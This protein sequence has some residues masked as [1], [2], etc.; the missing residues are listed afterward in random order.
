MPAFLGPLVGFALGVALA[1]LA[2]EEAARAD[3]RRLGARGVIAALYGALVFAPAAA[4]FL[5]FAGDWSYAYLLDS[6]A[7]PSAIE[8]GLV[9][10]DAASVPLGFLA[11]RRAGRD[12]RLTA[13]LGALPAAIS[14]GAALALYPKLRIAGTFHQVKGDFGTQP[15]AGS[16]TGW[17]ILWM[18]ALALAGF[19]IAARAMSSRDRRAPPQP[20]EPEP[21]RAFLGQR[22]RR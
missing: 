15:V 22:G 18:G 5:V 14:A 1:W 16:P 13:A 3:D 21:R 12:L 4:Y 9:I 6:R 19:A 8:L 7:V 17:A 10:L 11:A 20:A 2:R